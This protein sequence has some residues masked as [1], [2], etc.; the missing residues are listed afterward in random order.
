LDLVDEQRL[1]V[2]VNESGRVRPGQ[3]EH[4]SIVERY[5]LSSSR[6][7]GEVQKG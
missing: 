5:Y 1:R 4:G 7:G 6:L 2:I 3:S